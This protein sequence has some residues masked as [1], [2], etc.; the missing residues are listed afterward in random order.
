MKTADILWDDVWWPRANGD[1]IS[2]PGQ[3]V[4]IGE[5]WTVSETVPRIDGSPPTEGEMVVG[6]T[7][8]HEFGHYYYGLKDEYEGSRPCP[9]TGKWLWEH[10]E[11]KLRTCQ[12]DTAVNNSV[13]NDTYEAIDISGPISVV[14]TITEVVWLNFSTDATNAGLGDTF[15]SGQNNQWR[16]YEASGWSTLARDPA[17]DPKDKRI[18]VSRKMKDCD[19]TD[20]IIWCDGAQRLEKRT[21]TQYSVRS[22][23]SHYPELAA[24][25][26]ISTSVPPF[27]QSFQITSADDID[28]ARAVLSVEFTGGTSLTLA[29]I[30]IT[31]EN[32]KSGTQIVPFEVDSSVKEIVISIAYPTDPGSN[33][34]IVVKDADD[35]DQVNTDCLAGGG[36]VTFCKISVP[37]GGSNTPGSWTA[38]LLPSDPGIEISYEIIGISK[39]H[40]PAYRPYLYVVNAQPVQYPEAAVLVAGVD[41]KYPITSLG[42][43]VS[44]RAPDD[45]ESMLILRDDGESP[46]FLGGDGTYTGFLPYDQNGVYHVTAEFHN[47]SGTAI[48]TTLGQDDAL[49]VSTPIGQNFQRTLSIR[50]EVTDVRSDDHG[51]TPAE[52]TAIDADNLETPGRIEYAQDVDVFAVTSPHT[53]DLV[54]RVTGLAMDMVPYVQLLAADGVTVLG[55]FTDGPEVISYPLIK[56][57]VTAGET[58]YV[59]VHHADNAAT[60]GLYHVSAG[61]QLSSESGFFE[62]DDPVPAHQEDPNGNGDPTDDDT[63]GDGKPDYQDS[64]DDGDNIPTKNEDENG[65]GDPTDDDTDGDGKPDYQDNDDDDDG[66]LT[67]EE[68]SN[69]NGDPTDDDSDG[70]GTPNYQDNDDDD[71][72]ILTKEEDSNNNGDPTDDDTDKDGIPDYRD[73]DDD[74]DGIETSA[75]DI[76]GDGDPTNDDSDQD[77]IPDYRDNDDVAS[78]QL[79]YLPLLAK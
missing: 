44:V 46:D 24:V 35:A 21:R 33:V 62:D 2:S 19:G 64:D 8:A 60:N 70:D 58:V 55:E 67:K 77:G 13:M 10:I 4:Y 78:N 74:G 5:R 30:S 57:T 36:K 52:A 17:D 59:A 66:I 22:D 40:T 18:T 42:L 38:V 39:T 7:L 20:Y 76:N 56:T 41:D 51:N 68:D 26:P 14:K 72:G 1:G 65:N 75:E 53:G 6:Y 43:D 73:S 54:V 69:N 34:N 29:P 27:Q 47:D 37:I 23:R 45:Q 25:A 16:A 71:D 49:D 28:A 61:T 79:L 50:V 31:K 9:P 12:T 15:R 48:Y 32:K 11:N 63:D 3:H